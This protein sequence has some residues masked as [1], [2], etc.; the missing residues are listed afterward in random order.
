M[1]PEIEVKFLNVNHDEVRAK[2]KALGAKLEHPMRLM[3]RAMFDYPDNRLQKERPH[4]RLRVRDEGDKITITLKKSGDGDS[5][6]AG[7]VETIV[8]SFENMTEILKNVGLYIYSFQESKRET[9]MLEGTEVVLDEWPW[10]RPYIEIEGSTEESIKSVAKKLD[11]DWIDAVFGSVDAVYRAEYSKMTV[12]DSVGDLKE[13][14]F[15]MP[16]PQ[17]FK[18]RL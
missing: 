12:D 7:E 18:E 6:Y 13:V 3:R 17:Y 1:K 4:R 15:D 11:F 14:K 10:I 16:I 9:W 2:L 8:E 5:S